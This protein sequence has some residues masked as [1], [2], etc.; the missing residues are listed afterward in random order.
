MVVAPRQ[1]HVQRK[2]HEP[3]Q[4]QELLG[5]A[6]MG[7]GS[8]GALGSLM[9]PHPSKSKTVPDIDCRKSAGNIMAGQR[10][11]MLRKL[12]VPVVLPMGT[13]ISATHTCGN[14]PPPCA[15]HRQ[16]QEAGHLPQGLPGTTVTHTLPWH[17]EVT[18]PAA[19]P[20][21]DASLTNVPGQ[22]GSQQ[23]EPRASTRKGQAGLGELQGRGLAPRDATPSSCVQSKAREHTSPRKSTHV[24]L[25]KENTASTES[26]PFC[27]L[28]CFPAD[29]LLFPHSITAERRHNK[30]T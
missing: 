10:L 22:R 8:A 28:P 18:W 17:K 9:R 2:P 26:S 20:G 30:E 24:Q 16:L 11:Q 21:E 27:Q 7:Q 13:A 25:G 4:R 1:G 3:V 15:I 12:L 5:R 14:G 23:G 29:L 19:G 6:K